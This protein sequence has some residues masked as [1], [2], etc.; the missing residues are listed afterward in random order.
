MIVFIKL[1][2]AHLIGDFILQ[3]TSWVQDKEKKK[4]KSI[5]LYIHASLQGI[6]S[7]ILIGDPWFVG[8]ALLLVAIHGF[9][10]YVKLFFQKKDNKRTWFIIDQ[11]AHLVSLAVIVIAYQNLTFEINE[12]NAKPFWILVTATLFL[13]KPSSIII[14]NIITIWTPENNNKK[15][16]SL[17]N[18]G[19]FIGILERLFILCFI[20]THH[21]EAIGFLLAAKSIFRFGDL[22]AAKDR[23]LT[24]YVLIGT[25]LSFGL[26][27]FIGLMTDFLLQSL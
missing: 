8:Y 9:I 19:N 21:F 10:D 25:L 2:L 20:L 6:L 27:I 13:T 11:I 4:L 14:K 7:W 1:L 17:A 5:Y 3:P 22:K 15:D 24:E 26:A 18:A 23:K 16:N 12:E